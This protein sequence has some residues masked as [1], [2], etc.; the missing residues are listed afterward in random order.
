MDTTAELL[1]LNLCV[2]DDG[3]MFSNEFVIIRSQKKEKKQFML[4]LKNNL[5]IVSILIDHVK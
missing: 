2:E 1:L 3:H 5:Q 4:F